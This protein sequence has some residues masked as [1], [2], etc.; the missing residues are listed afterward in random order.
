MPRMEQRNGLVGYLHNLVREHPDFEVLCEPTVDLYCFRYL[1]NDLS[2]DKDQGEVGQLL[3]RLNAEIVE[4]VQRE[5]P[6]LVTKMY[7]DG[8]VAI[9]IWLSAD[10]TVREDV[11]STFEAIAR[12]G[13]MC[14]KKLLSSVVG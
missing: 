3:D 7:V 14:N 12:R 1:P 2:E 6:A 13:R 5:G 8:H 10:R 9:C 11:D 4:D